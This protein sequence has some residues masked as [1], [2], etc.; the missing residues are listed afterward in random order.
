M[1]QK[2]RHILLFAGFLT[3]IAAGMGFGIR[4][5]ILGEW[6][7]DF[8]FT[9]TELGT[10]TGGGLIGFGLVILIAGF[11]IDLVG[12]KNL[13]MIA[14]ALHIISAVMTLSADFAFASGD[15]ANKAAVYSLLFWSMMLFAVAN[16]ICEA[17]INPLTATLYPEQKTHYLN[18]LHAGW[19][20]GLVLGGLVALLAGKIPWEILLGLFLVPVVIYGFIVVSQKF[21]ATEAK[22]SG[23]SWGSMLAD[24]VT[25]FLLV[26]LF[27]HAMVGYVELGTDSW[28]QRITGSIMNSAVLGTVLFIYTSLLM[29]ALRFFAGPIV[30]R[31]SSLGL[32]LI[33]SII[34]ALGL[35]LISV[36][37]GVA[38][39]WIAVT[40][41]A[42]GKTFLWPTMLGVVGEQF[43]R[44]ATVA[45]ALLGAA[46]MLS[47][48]YLGSPGI[49]YKQDYFASSNLKEKSPETY[50][51]YK[52]TEG[53]GFLLFPKVVGLDGSKVDGVALHG[54][55]PGVELNKRLEVL[56]NDGKTLDDNKEL[57]ELTTWWTDAKPHFANEDEK[58]L[59]ASVLDGSRKAM[60]V[61]A[62][63]PAT[64]AVM[65]LL[66]I[67]G[68]K[69]R[70]GYK[71]KGVEAATEEPEATPK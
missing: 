66:M 23:M 63:V 8:G 37:S 32:L 3:L 27:T 36:S 68:F 1:A 9:A 34:G 30:H 53:K 10:I 20:G 33:S 41:Y 67:L 25:P 26:L 2:N 24:C 16:G 39:M 17:V 58:P 48:G 14:L 6:A 38:L 42:V 65:Y 60:L 69:A 43:P 18:I 44:S 4:G 62:A 49:G 59:K 28:I 47:A 46:G 12:Y 29:F 5:G 70:G 51:R 57:K 13:L 11:F 35:V 40:V 50:E 19:P 31:I 56:K 54:A 61:T 21:P 45:M 15:G 22:A 71:I 52:A 55:G 7:S 64:M